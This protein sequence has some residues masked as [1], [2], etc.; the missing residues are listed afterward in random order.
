MKILHPDKI[1]L[2]SIQ[3]ILTS[4]SPIALSEI[5]I[6]RILRCRQY[7]EEKIEFEDQAIYGVNT[8]FGALCDERISNSDLEKLQENLLM[9]HACGT[10]DEA[11]KELVRMMI[12][13]KIH[14][15]ALGHSGVQ[16]QTV[17][18]LIDF[19]NE[20]IIPVVFTQGSLGAS[21][22]LSPLAHLSL[23][24]IGKGEVFYKNEK[25]LASEVLEETGLQPIRLK[26][27]EGLALL[28]GT[29]FMSAYG[30]YCIQKFY[31]LGFF[32]NGC[33]ESFHN[34]SQVL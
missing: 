8:G 32:S 14:A 16:L 22:D 34:I 25:R 7:L 12:L 11:P 5:A 3:D 29:Q 31:C 26:S 10:G 28:N 23:P 27:K 15:L 18:R 33:F 1:T 21:G 24:L 20:D 9:S 6:E 17:Q 19:L 30:V 13:L 2:E 4:A